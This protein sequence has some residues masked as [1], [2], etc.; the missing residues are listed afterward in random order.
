M[1]RLQ[2]EDHKSS[3]TFERTLS[4]AWG[5]NNMNRIDLYNEMILR[6]N[7]RKAKAQA[8]WVARNMW[9]WDGVSSFIGQAEEV[10]A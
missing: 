8:G 9:G 2:T 6:E 4:K 1:N 3:R 7:I 5:D 10:A